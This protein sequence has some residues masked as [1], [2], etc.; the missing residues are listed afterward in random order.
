MAFQPCPNIVEAAVYTRGP[1]QQV[2]ANVLHFVKTPSGPLEQADVNRIAAAVSLWCNNQLKTI[3]SNQVSI[4]GF[5]V[6]ALD[7]ENGPVN[8]TTFTPA[9]GGTIASG[10]LPS[11]NTLSVRH[12]VGIAGRGLSGRSFVPSV[13]E[14][15]IVGDY[16]TQTFADNCVGVFNAI[17]SVLAAFPEFQWCTLSRR[18]GKAARPAGIARI[19]QGA[20][21]RDRRVD[22]QRRR[23]PRTY[24]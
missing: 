7:V 10:T 24:Q 23:L 4:S 16:V 3:L 18:S 2:M 1:D 15:Q 6:R 22:T 11:V 17:M 20:N 5:R 9:I 19:I 12:D 8:E 21:V 13:P 14:N